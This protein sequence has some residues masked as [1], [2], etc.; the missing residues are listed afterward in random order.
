MKSL[1]HGSSGG[2]GHDIIIVVTGSKPV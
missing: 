2:I 1:T